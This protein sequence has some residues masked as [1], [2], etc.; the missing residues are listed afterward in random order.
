MRA[1]QGVGRAS[2]GRRARPTCWRAGCR[3]GA[4]A[5]GGG[6]ECAV[7]GGW[8]E[9]SAPAGGRQAVR[10]RHPDPR[11][12]GLEARRGH[13]GGRRGRAQGQRWRCWGRRPAR[14]GGLQ[15]IGSAGADPSTPRLHTT[16]PRRDARP[17]RAQG[18]GAADARLPCALSRPALRPSA[19]SAHRPASA[20]AIG[21]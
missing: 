19:S 21:C 17:T 3:Q 10:R 8:P 18:L 2:A 4:Q 5:G 7:A 14:S 1:L 11:T 6:R 13:G 20:A 16:G 15:A 9:G 12:L